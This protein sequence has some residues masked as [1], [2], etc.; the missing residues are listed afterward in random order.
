[1]MTNCL[2]AVIWL[3]YLVTGLTNESDLL[4]KF[5]HI[6]TS[7]TY[8]THEQT[9]TVSDSNSA[10]D[11]DNGWNFFHYTDDDEIW[12]ENDYVRDNITE[13]GLNGF[14]LWSVTRDTA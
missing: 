11:V 7:F 10:L 8:I 1:M 6:L 12:V 13:V 9:A 14:S 3:P 5:N 2:V 4:A